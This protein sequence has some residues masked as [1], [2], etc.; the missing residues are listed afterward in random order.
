MPIDNKRIESSTFDK[1]VNPTFEALIR[2]KGA[3]HTNDQKF[4]WTR[5]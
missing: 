4:A 5:Q 2:L 3:M 1:R